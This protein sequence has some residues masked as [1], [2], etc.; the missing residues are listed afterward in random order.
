MPLPEGA[1]R[2][3]PTMCSHAFCALRT[4]QPMVAST[5]VDASPRFGPGLGETKPLLALCLPK[6][7]RSLPPVADSVL[8][9]TAPRPSLSGFSCISGWARARKYGRFNRM[10]AVLAAPSRPISRRIRA[11]PPLDRITSI[12]TQQLVPSPQSVD[13]SVSTHPVLVLCAMAMLQTFV[14]GAWTSVQQPLRL[15]RDLSIPT[16]FT[17]GSPQRLSDS[18]PVIDETLLQAP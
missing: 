17:P 11:E 12:A 6:D 18:G 4:R 10:V 9:C 7:L 15:L 5:P 8:A 16:D 13:L 2:G 14:R 3:R 1:G